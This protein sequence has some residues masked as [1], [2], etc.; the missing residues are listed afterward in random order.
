MKESQQW[1]QQRFVLGDARVAQMCRNMPHL[2][3]ANTTTLSNKAESIQTALSLDDEELSNLVSKY[4]TIF[5]FSIEEK[6]RPTLRYLRMR[7]ELDEEALKNLVLKAPSLFSYSE[8]NIEEK[9]Q[10]YSNLVGEREA[11]RMVVKSSNLLKQSLKKRL[12]P[13]L[14]EIQKSGVKVRWTETLM[15]RLAIR[16]NN[17][18][19]RYK[20]GD[21]PRG[22]AAKPKE[23]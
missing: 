18:W 17:Q 23:Q 21:A 20:L 12:K 3:Y 13:R 6:T 22:G 4:S 8:G 1:I 5:C 19:E 7:F 14:E 15:R 2:L 16:T 11:K 9:L 10:F